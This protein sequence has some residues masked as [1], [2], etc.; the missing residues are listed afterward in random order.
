LKWLF[1]GNDFVDFNKKYLQKF[2]KLPQENC[3]VN[4]FRR[5][6]LS[7]LGIFSLNGC[8]NDLRWA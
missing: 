7:F 3:F 1:G 6:G 8:T 2:T 5:K 4:A